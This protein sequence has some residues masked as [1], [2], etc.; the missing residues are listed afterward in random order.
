MNWREALVSDDPV[1]GPRS[2]EPLDLRPVR[3]TALGMRRLSWL[4]FALFVVLTWRIAA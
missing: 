4:L 3:L 1:P 2:D